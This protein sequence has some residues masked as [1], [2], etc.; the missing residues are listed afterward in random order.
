M[1]RDTQVRQQVV[2][3]LD[4][5]HL[6]VVDRDQVEAGVGRVAKG[7]VE[8]EPAMGEARLEVRGYWRAVLGSERC[9]RIHGL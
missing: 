1:G 2:K 3:E 9:V 5:L 4:A 8:A 6:L 7:D